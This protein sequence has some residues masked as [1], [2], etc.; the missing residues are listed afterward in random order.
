MFEDFGN[1]KKI[2]DVLRYFHSKDIEITKTTLYRHGKEGKLPKNKDG[3]YTRLLLKKYAVAHLDMED[4]FSD[5]SSESNSLTAELKR[6]KIIR[7]DLAIQR[8]SLAWEIEQGKYTPTAA[9]DRMFIG[10]ALMFDRA[11]KS[12]IQKHVAELIAL[13]GGKQDK[14]PQLV[15]FFNERFDVIL[16]DYSQKTWVFELLKKDYE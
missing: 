14:A 12:F 15:D 13:V 4:D 10:R 16:K 2:S 3:F 5:D 8:E 1:T 7:E 11:R 9:I 6:R